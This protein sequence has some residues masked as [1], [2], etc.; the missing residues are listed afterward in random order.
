MTNKTKLPGVWRDLKCPKCQ[1]PSGFTKANTDEVMAKDYVKN[2]YCNTCQEYTVHEWLG[3][4][5]EYGN[6][7]KNYLELNFE[8]A[9]ND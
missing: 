8:S 2:Y 6:N 7:G 4:P 1:E 3:V 5:W 9:T